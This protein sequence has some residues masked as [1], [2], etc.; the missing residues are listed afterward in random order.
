[1]RKIEISD[2]IIWISLIILIAYVIGKL[3]GL[4]NTPE[5]LSLLPLISL[6][7]FA[8]AFYQK[9]LGFMGQMYQRT[10]YLKKKLNEHDKRFDNISHQLS[11]HDSRLSILEKR[12]K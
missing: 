9:V 1:M 12:K 6:I 10:D 2:I 3:T 7:F 8:G 4:I 11:N 5:W